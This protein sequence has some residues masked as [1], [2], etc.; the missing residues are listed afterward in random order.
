[1]KIKSFMMMMV[2][3]AAVVLGVSSCGS[4]DD[5]P[6]VAVAEQVAGSYTGTEVMIVMGEPDEGTKTF[7]F[8]KST[9]IS[10]DMVIPEY[11][12][13]MMSLP[14]MP[15]KNIPLTKNGN[16]ITGKLAS[17]EG[18]VTNASGDEKTYTVSDLVV[19]FSDKTVA[20]TFKLKYGNMPFDFEGQ[21]TG[22]KQ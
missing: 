2:A 5:E 21:F 10:V 15:V 8:T 20:V 14:K 12:E 7:E 16:T 22:T 6:E 13:S 1:M 3:A 18:K 9:E 11:G 17:Y 19:I 4:D